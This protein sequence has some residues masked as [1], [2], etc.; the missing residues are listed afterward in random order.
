MNITP[1]QRLQQYLQTKRLS[2]TKFAEICDTNKSILS[3]IGEATSQATLSKIEQKSDI[4]LDWL[5]TGEGSMIRPMIETSAVLLGK[6]VA[7]IKENLVDVKFYEVTPSATF[8]DYCQGMAE[9]PDYISII[10]MH[11]ETIDDSSCVFEINGDSMAPQIRDKAMVLCSE[12]PP[13]RWHSLHDC[14]VVIAYRDKFV[15]KRIS[16][17]RLDSENYLILESDN[18][19]IPGKEDVQLADIRCIFKAERIISQRIS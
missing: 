1:K 5:L 15:I 12:V 4:N 2:L 7:E 14:V 3:R 16:K 9:N 10:P 19:E 8:K 18:P 6:P 13:T 17:N 11:G